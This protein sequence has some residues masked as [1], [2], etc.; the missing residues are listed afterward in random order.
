M[1]DMLSR[2]IHVLNPRSGPY[3]YNQGKKERHDLIVSRLHD[4]LFHC[5]SVFF[6]SWP[7]KKDNWGTMYPRIVDTKLSRDESA[8][9]SLQ[10]IR[11][12]DGDKLHLPLTKLNTSKMKCMALHECMKLQGIISTIVG[13][14]LWNALAP[15]DTFEDF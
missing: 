5:F 11:Y 9:V 3:G 7:I 6:A 12:Y 4:A 2:S 15:A 8:F 10:I 14:V 1:W 13:D